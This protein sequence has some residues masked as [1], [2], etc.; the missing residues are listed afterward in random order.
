MNMEAWGSSPNANVASSVY[1]DGT[2]G[3]AGANAERQTGAAGDITH[4]KVCF[5]AGHVPCLCGE[6]AGVILF[7]ANRGRISRI[8]VKIQNRCSGPQTDLAGTAY[9]ERIRRGARTNLK[10]DRAGF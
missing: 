3:R 9:P 2:G 5:V 7:E 6:T 10:Y 4:E 1:V 8:H